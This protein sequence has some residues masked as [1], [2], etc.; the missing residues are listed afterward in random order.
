MARVRSVLHF[1]G[2]PLD[3][4]T[5]TDSILSQ[6]GLAVAGAGAGDVAMEAGGS[7]GGE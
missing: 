4:R 3:A 2:L 6:E 1:N 5:V 7:T